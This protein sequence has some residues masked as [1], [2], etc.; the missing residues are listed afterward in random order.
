MTDDV[1]DNMVVRGFPG[2]IPSWVLKKEIKKTT[3]ICIIYV[4]CNICCIYLIFILYILY[5]AYKCRV[6]SEWYINRASFTRYI[7]E[8]T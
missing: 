3:Y 5:I 1:T 6:K 4:I 8:P 7:V 2:S